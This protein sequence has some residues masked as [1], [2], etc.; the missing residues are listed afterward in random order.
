MLHDIHARKL[1]EPGWPGELED[2]ELDYI[3]RRLFTDPRV[4][5]RWGFAPRQKTRPEAAIR[6]VATYGDPERRDANLRLARRR[7][8]S[9]HARSPIEMAMGR[10]NSGFK[11]KKAKQ[12]PTRLTDRPRNRALQIN[13]EL[14]GK[15]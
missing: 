7:N 14:F 5:Y 10:G 3:K 9:S 6:R 12:R 4:A 2:M 13:L 1:L 8:S 15:G 11:V